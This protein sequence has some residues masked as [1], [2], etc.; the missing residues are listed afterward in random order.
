MDAPG[1]CVTQRVVGLASLRMPPST[2]SPC[3]LA[4]SQGTATV[5]PGGSDELRTAVRVSAASSVPHGGYR[6][7][8]AAGG[9]PASWRVRRPC[10]WADAPGAW[11]QRHDDPADHL[12]Q[13]PRW[14][15]S[16]LSSRSRLTTRRPSARVRSSTAARSRPRRLLRGAPTQPPHNPLRTR[17]TQKA[18]NRSSGLWP[19]PRR[20]RPDPGSRLRDD[21]RLRQRRVQLRVTRGSP[22]TRCGCP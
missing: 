14:S 22:C 7:G 9:C 16:Q 5:S 11:T 3:V 13:S 19:T 12:R 2:A 10:R 8:D 4:R 17:A 18:V 20:S 6:G 1:R 15:L 21:V